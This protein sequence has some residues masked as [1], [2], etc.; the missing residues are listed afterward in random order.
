MTTHTQA[1][2][3]ARSALVETFG[4]DPTYGE[5]AALAAIACLETNYGQGW[6]GTGVGSHNM[7]AIQCGPSWTGQRFGSID[8]HPNADGTSTPYRIEFRKYATELDGWLDLVRVVYI[9]R[10]RKIVRQAAC[11]ESWCDVSAALYQTGYFEGYGKTVG[12]R[13]HNHLLALEGALARANT[14]IEAA[15]P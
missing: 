6:K 13:I 5:I 12:D 14:E 11:N 10:G 9:N 4:G 7:G 15:T 8:T 3:L 2:Q 1:R